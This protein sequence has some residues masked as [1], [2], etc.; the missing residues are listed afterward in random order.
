[1]NRSNV[2]IVTK[3]LYQSNLGQRHDWVKLG[4]SREFAKIIKG[5]L[6]D[7]KTMRSKEFEQ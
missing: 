1:M 7:Q 2:I 6:K 5:K 4:Q 3:L